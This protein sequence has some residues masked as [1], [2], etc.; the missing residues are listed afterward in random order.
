M[1]RGE[2]SVDTKKCPWTRRNVYRHFVVVHGH[3][4]MSIDILLD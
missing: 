3:E 4:E 1:F 2:M